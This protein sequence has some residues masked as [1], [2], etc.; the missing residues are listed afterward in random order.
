M[1]EIP[2]IARFP[3][4]HN[5]FEWVNALHM[6]A[7]DYGFGYDVFSWIVP[8]AHR[9]SMME[10]HNP[11][12]PWHTKYVVWKM[13]S[14]VL[15]V[16]KQDTGNGVLIR[17]YLTM[18]LEGDL[19]QKDFD[20]FHSLLNEEIDARN[21]ARHWVKKDLYVV[22]RQARSESDVVRQDG[23]K[24][25]KVNGVYITLTK[26]GVDCFIGI[27]KFTK[28]QVIELLDYAIVLDE[29]GH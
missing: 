25:F 2:E 8:N 19:D 3:K 17:S 11:E 16:C 13:C 14:M 4:F 20:F 15:K 18:T 6:C 29:E 1:N 12:G 27:E 5:V 28:E 21:K 10:E 24:L 26:S 23:D 7:K 9:M 22:H